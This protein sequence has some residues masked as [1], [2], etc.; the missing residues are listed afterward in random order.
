MKFTEANLE[1]VFIELLS[2]GEMEYS[3][4]SSCFYPPPLS[5]RYVRTSPAW[6]NAIPLPF[7]AGQGRASPPTA[8]SR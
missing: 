3:S 6:D 8:S 5:F 2:A 7:P 1:P 4:G